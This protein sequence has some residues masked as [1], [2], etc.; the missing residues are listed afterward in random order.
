MIGPAAPLLLAAYG[1]LLGRRPGGSGDS[2]AFFPALLL[3]LIL[4]G[5]FFVYIITPRNVVEHMGTSL[6][7]LLMQLWPL[8][9]F[10]FFLFIATP[11][12][13]WAKSRQAH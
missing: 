12:E 6:D 2:G 11:G 8:C 13:A 5:Y 4:A 10:A 9:L 3:T 1:A 7:R